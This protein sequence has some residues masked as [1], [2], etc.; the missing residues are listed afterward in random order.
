M[1]KAITVF[2]LRLVR[3]LATVLVMA[4][5]ALTGPL[6]L[7]MD[8]TG[9]GA[10]S[11]YPLYA[12]WAAAYHQLTG[13]R[14]N[15]Q[16]MG[17]GGGQQQILAGTVDFGASDDPL[18]ASWLARHGMIQFP[19]VVLGVV[20]V[21]H[22]PGIRPGELVLTGG[23]LADIYLGNI[24]R[25]NDS[26]IQALNPDLALPD[27]AIVVVHRADGSG[28]TFVW[29]DYLSQASA[30]WRQRVGT[31]KA[32][33]WPVGQGGKGNEGVAAYVRQLRYAIGYIEY[34]YAVTNNLTWTRLKNAAGV[35]VAPNTDSIAASAQAADWA[36]PGMGVSLNNQ[37][38]STAWP[39]AAA[40]F[41]LVPQRPRQPARIKEVLRFFDWAWSEGQSI[42]TELA[43]VP[44]PSQ[45]QQKVSLAWQRIMDLND[46]SLWSAP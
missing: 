9:A 24:T 43:Y 19:A 21:V 11:P 17:S 41:I 18:P 28:T 46:E 4:S 2:N 12:K 25:W 40:S 8:L 27:R 3:F 32:V 42:T 26:A 1:M 13:H 5:L 23:V 39:I 45:A 44:L 22:L 6:T 7:A 34:T 36:Q 16:S 37:P 33:A 14:I 10:S 15:Y 30:S 20:P 38:A 31:G 29:S 35:E